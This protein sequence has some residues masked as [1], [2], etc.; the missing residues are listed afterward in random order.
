MPVRFLEVTGGTLHRTRHVH[1]IEYG[2]AVEAECTEDRDEEQLDGWPTCY[3]VSLLLFEEPPVPVHVFRPVEIGE[4]E[5]TFR[6]AL[7]DDQ[8]VGVGIEEARVVVLAA[9]LGTALT[10]TG[11][12][13]RVLP[14]RVTNFVHRFSDGPR[15]DTY[16]GFSD[17][18]GLAL[19]VVDWLDHSYSAC[20]A[21]DSVLPR[22]VCQCL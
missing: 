13:L 16:H 9:G 21:L 11:A 10:R 6:R 14:D 22:F 5:V 17:A 3:H 2:V 7:L 15:E 4:P 18:I 12:A 8:D 20:C 19:S 1:L